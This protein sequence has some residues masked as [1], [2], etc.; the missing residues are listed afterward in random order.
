M[1]LTQRARALTAVGLGDVLFALVI[2]YWWE[3]FT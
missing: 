3:F 2:P 1:A